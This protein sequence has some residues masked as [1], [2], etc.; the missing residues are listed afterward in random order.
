MFHSVP[1]PQPQAQLLLNLASVMLSGRQRADGR[2]AGRRR[3][4]ASTYLSKAWEVWWVVRKDVVHSCSK[5]KAGKQAW[6]GAGQ[7]RP[8]TPDPLS[9]L[10]SG[11]RPNT[12]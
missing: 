1:L 12:T 6:G 9:L 2:Q 4:A 7:P 5:Q 10:P 3:S 8:P 11:S